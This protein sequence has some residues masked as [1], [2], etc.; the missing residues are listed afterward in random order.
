MRRRV[1][2]EIKSMLSF[3]TRITR[4]LLLLDR[5]NQVQLRVDGDALPNMHDAAPLFIFRQER[6]VL[7]RERADALPRKQF[8]VTRWHATNHEPSGGIAGGEEVKS[9]VPTP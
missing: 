2:E 3:A 7:V 6:R 8:V 9:K 1:A 4:G 5:R